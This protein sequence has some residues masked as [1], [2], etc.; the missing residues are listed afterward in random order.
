MPEEVACNLCGASRT[1]LLFRLRD[2]RFGVDDIDWNIVQCRSCGLGYLNPRPTEDEIGRYYP[3]SYFNSR[4][5]HRER[6]KR[7]AAYLEGE[8]GRLLDIGTARGDFLA[9]MAELGWDVEGIEPFEDAGNPFD[10]TIHH[11]RFPGGNRLESDSYDVITAWAVFEHLHDPASAFRE[12][13][14]I[15]R[16][17][18]VLIAQVPNLRSIY[19]RWAKQ[20]DVPRHLYFFNE[21]TLREFGQ[22]ARLELSNVWHTTD[23]F[24][25]SGRGV[26]R[27]ALVRALGRS[28]PEFFEIWR[29]PRPERLRRWPVL[30]V[31]WTAVAA[32][33]RVLLSDWIVRTARISGQIV[34]RFEKSTTLSLSAGLRREG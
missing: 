5:L 18:G 29:A 28:T 24:G 16:P 17:G 33:E 12:C 7:Q 6:Y 4:Q 27:L 10:L 34:V 23:L 3:S 22:M 19:S 13:A 32:L 31:A 8:G 14:R 26:L 1:R 2:Y 15:L 30:T 25:G 11:E 20:E 21:R 9:V